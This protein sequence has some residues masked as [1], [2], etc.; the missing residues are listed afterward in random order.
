LPSTIDPNGLPLWLRDFNG[1]FDTFLSTIHALALDEQR[2]RIYAAGS[3]L[4]GRQSCRTLASLHPNNAYMAV[5]PTP[6]EQL[7]I[8]LFGMVGG[9][10]PNLRT[11]YESTDIVVDDADNVVVVGWALGSLLGE[12]QGLRDAFVVSF[13]AEGEQR[14]AHLFGTSESDE[15]LGVAVDQDN[16]V[17]VTGFLKVGRSEL[18]TSQNAGHEVFLAKYHP[19]GQQLWLQTFAVSP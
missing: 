16:A 11:N 9:G 5:C 8:G 14:W 4:I 1:T 7:D 6:E 10:D 17:Y 3:Q 12:H 19:D 15:A 2:G 13:N 18:G